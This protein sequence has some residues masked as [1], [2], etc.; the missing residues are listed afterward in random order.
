MATKNRF[1]IEEGDEKIVGSQQKSGRSFRPG[2]KAPRKDD[3]L[4][5]TDGVGTPDPLWTRII[6]YLHTATDITVGIPVQRFPRTNA[7]LAELDA[8]GA[9]G[10]NLQS[11]LT[12]G[13]VTCV[14]ILKSTDL[15]SVQF[16]HGP[17]AAGDDAIGVPLSG[18]KLVDEIS[19]LPQITHRFA[20]AI[21]L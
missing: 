1:T 14:K 6:N 9:A 7:N 16:M 17:I 5:F 13:L 15:H 11:D 20:A 3:L 18:V 10:M 4:F 21:R 8:H 12:T 2:G 19:R